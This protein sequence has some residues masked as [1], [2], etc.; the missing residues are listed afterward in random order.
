MSEFKY[1]PV[2]S[3]VYTWGI[4]RT[5]QY[6][7]YGDFFKQSDLDVK[8]GDVVLDAGCGNL[9]LTCLFHEEY[10]DERD[11]E[12][13]VIGFDKSRHMLRRGEKYAR[14]NGFFGHANLFKVDALQIPFKDNSVDLV[15]SSGMLEYLSDDL[16]GVA[17]ELSRVLKPG[18]QM[19]LSFEKNNLIGRIIGKFWGFKPYD[20]D[21][22]LSHFKDI[23]FEDARFRT[24]NFH[25]RLF[26][27]IC[28]GKKKK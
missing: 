11:I 12:T 15:M 9:F 1:G 25:T 24:W 3:S 7:F 26:K 2:S 10:L 17:S 23:D 14:E 5:G 28:V 4:K 13:R 8:P 20:K 19:V 22:L 6:T 21:Y 16:E 18:K 27:N